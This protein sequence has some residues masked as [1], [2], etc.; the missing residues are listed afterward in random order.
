MSPAA[1][2]YTGFFVVWGLVFP[3]LLPIILKVSHANM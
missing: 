2:F 3:F 1:K